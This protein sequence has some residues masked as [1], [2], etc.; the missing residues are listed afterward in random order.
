M[1]LKTFTLLASTALAA[2]FAGSDLGH[3]H[4]R[5]D[6]AGGRPPDRRRAGECG[7]ERG[8]CEQGECLQFH[9]DPPR[10]SHCVRNQRVL[11]ALYPCAVSADC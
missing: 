9:G 2:A 6:G 8:A 5:F 1:K 7:S 3:R 11:A 4:V 10:W